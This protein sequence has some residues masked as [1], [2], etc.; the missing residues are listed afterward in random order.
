MCETSTEIPVQSRRLIGR[1]ESTPTVNGAPKLA[2]VQEE[3]IDTDV[4]AGL[5]CVETDFTGNQTHP[6]RLREVAPA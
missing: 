3:G 1:L 5:S 4:D 6:L 2:C